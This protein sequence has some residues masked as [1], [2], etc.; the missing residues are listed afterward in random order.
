[1]ILIIKYILLLIKPIF[2]VENFANDST[3]C[4]QIAYEMRNIYF[5]RALEMKSNIF[6]C[7]RK[8]HKLNKVCESHIVTVE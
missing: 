2:F 5:F 1:M 4:L 6:Q 8:E 3:D 7:D